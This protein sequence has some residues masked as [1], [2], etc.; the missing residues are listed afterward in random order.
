MR[1]L[2]PR[3]S[4][5]PFLTRWTSNLLRAPFFFVATIS[6]GSVA[7]VS[8]LFDKSGR[9]Q[10]RIAQS[11]AKLA[12]RVSGARLHVI[13][14]E[15]LQRHAVAVYASN[16]LSY[17]DT[18]VIFATLPD[19]FRIVAR[20]TLW[21]LPFIGWYLAHSGQIAVNVENPRASVA[22]LSSGVKTLKDG[23]PLFIFPE[24]GRTRTGHTQR[25]LNG[26]AFMAIRA[27]VPI[28]PMALIGTH[29]LL[30]IHTREFYP[31]PVVVA[32]G[33]P[34]DTSEY[35]LREVDALTERLEKTITSLFYEHSY[36][37]RPTLAQTP[38]E[39]T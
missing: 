39:L 32:V 3:P 23:M 36:L 13:G 4:P 37:E 20:S 21:K 5:L 22:S 18:P 11:W 9:V 6:C 38:A 35:T 10:H 1:A 30:P 12:V 8:S 17:M 29:E 33:E 26:P 19:Q 28:I 14:A 25:F 31:V 2:T 7:M 34:I 16:H 27:R 15:R 24:G